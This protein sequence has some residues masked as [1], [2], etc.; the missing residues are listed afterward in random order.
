MHESVKRDQC[1]QEKAFSIDITVDNAIF[2]GSQDSGAEIS[3]ISKC[4]W[5]A[6]S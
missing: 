2:C 5:K 1:H 4:V 3:L 6:V